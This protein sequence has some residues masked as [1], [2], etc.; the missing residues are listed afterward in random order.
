MKTKL[1]LFAVVL[2]NVTTIFSQSDNNP[3]TK[4]ETKIAGDKLTLRGE[5]N[6]TLGL[7]LLFSDNGFGLGATFY[8]QFSSN[9]SGFAGISFSGAKDGRE[10]EQVDLFGN[11]NTP[12]K[13]NR[14]FMVPLNIGLQVRMFRADVSDNLR[15]FINFGVTPTAIIYTPYNQSWFSAWGYA[16]AKYTVGGFVGIGMDYL[17]NHTSSLSMNVRYYYI[18][19][20]GDGVNS[21]S[22]SDKKFFGGLTFNFSYNFMH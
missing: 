7:N 10:F 20:F 22:T 15:P 16:R 13:V 21:I 11:T 19:L 18:N 12:Y 5:R 1:I 9:V 14:L 17:T 3:G 8:K 6:N 2:L 4:P